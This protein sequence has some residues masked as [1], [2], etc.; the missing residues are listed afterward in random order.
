MTRACCRPVNNRNDHRCA[1]RKD[2]T[3]SPDVKNRAYCQY[4]IF[5][6]LIHFHICFRTSIARTKGA[7]AKSCFDLPQLLFIALYFI[8]MLM[9]LFNNGRNKSV[10]RVIVIKIFTQYSVRLLNCGQTVVHNSLL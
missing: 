2:V 1:L 7:A 3:A 4:D 8:F 5:R 10:L 9:P 6:Y